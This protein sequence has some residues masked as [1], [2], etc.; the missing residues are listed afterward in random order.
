[1]IPRLSRTYKPMA[2]VL[3][4]AVHV[5]GDRR[6]SEREL[7]AQAFSA[8]E[9]A[10][11]GT[12]TSEDCVL[13]PPQG[14]SYFQ[15]A[16]LEHVVPVRSPIQHQT[17]TIVGKPGALEDDTET[18]KENIDHA[19]QNGNGLHPSFVRPKQMTFMTQNTPP[20]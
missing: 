2:F 3:L 6:G 10:L 19:D 4:F 15:A 8:P 5:L 17:R 7:S 11:F 18:S 16:S 1:M 20:R 12:C 9:Q 13:G 14:R